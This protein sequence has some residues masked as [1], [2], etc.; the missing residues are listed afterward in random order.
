MFKRI[1]YNAYKIN[2]PTSKYLV[3]DTFNVADLSPFLG[4]ARVQEDDESKTTLSEEGGDDVAPHVDNTMD[5][6][7][8]GPMTR[9]RVKALH[10]K[11][12]SLLSMCDLDLPLN[13]LLL[14][15]GTLCIL[16]I[17]SDDGTQWIQEDDQEKVQD[18]GEDEQG[19]ILEDGQGEEGGGEDRQ[20]GLE[21]G[22]GRAP[23]RAPSRHCRPPGRPRPAPR[24]VP[25]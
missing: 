1:N 17:H 3:H 6:T 12:T 5:T 23:G 15:A 18:D 8:N 22:L 7:P 25:H 2:I 10:E 19:E 11:V 9:S 20:A 16:R 4:D 13:G 21:A 24:P 14:H